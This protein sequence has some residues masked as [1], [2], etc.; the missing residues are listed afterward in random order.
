ML[1]RIPTHAAL[2]SVLA[3]VFALS[4]VAM[5]SAEPG[6][7][8]V[9]DVGAIPP[10]NCGGCSGSGS[11]GP[12]FR[13]D[14]GDGLRTQEEWD[15]ELLPDRRTAGLRYIFP[16]LDPY[17]PDTD[18]DGLNDGDEVRRSYYNHYGSQLIRR[19]TSPRLWDT[20]YDGYSD[21]LEVKY[22]RTDPTKPDTDGDGLSDRDEGVKYRTSPLKRDTDG[23]CIPDGTEVRQGSDPTRRAVELLRGCGSFTSDSTVAVGIPGTTRSSPRK[24]IH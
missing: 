22:T 9:D 21:G 6:R 18:S 12:A 16:S 24:Q 14:D 7:P 3:L 23:D 17:D 15:G 11:G 19:Y 10:Y 4:G 13:D 20:D 2:I 1:R 8:D 5:A